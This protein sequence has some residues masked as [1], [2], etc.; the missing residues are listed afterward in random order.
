M[1]NEHVPHQDNTF[2]LNS[3]PRHQLLQD[4]RNPNGYLT[5]A[6]F[7]MPIGPAA[8]P[9]PVQ[10]QVPNFTLMQGDGLGDSP[11]KLIQPTP[12][13]PI[14]HAPLTSDL[15]ANT[16]STMEPLSLSL[17]LSPPSGQGDSPSRHPAF[18]VMSSFRTGESI[19]SVA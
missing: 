9:V 17:N 13:V 11:S 8:F 5:I 4:T 15:S 10:N 7:P 6:P 3:M 1:E 14:P 2:Q 18:Q 19:I 12:L 16:K